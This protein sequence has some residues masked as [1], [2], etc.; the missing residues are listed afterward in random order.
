M[1]HPPNPAMH[2]PCPDYVRALVQRG[3]NG[4][5]THCA[6]AFGL[7]ARTVRRWVDADDVN[8]PYI[9]QWALEEY[10]NQKESINKCKQIVDN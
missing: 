9:A 7:T 6:H 3:F 8:I 4:N 10:A 5:Q 1:K 2:N